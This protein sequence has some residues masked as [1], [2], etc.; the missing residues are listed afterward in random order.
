MYFFNNK[1]YPAVR[2]RNF[3]SAVFS[4]LIGVLGFY[5][6]RGLGIFLFTTAPRMAPGLTQPLIQ[7]VL[8]ALSLEMKRPGG[9]DDH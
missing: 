4:L 1:F 2:L 6:R 3:F 9:E 8:G 7:W 5:S